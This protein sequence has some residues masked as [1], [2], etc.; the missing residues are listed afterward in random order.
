M[1]IAIERRD[2][3]VCEIIRR[4]LPD[5]GVAFLPAVPLRFGLEPQELRREF[6]AGRLRFD[7]S[8]SLAPDPRPGPREAV[9][10]YRRA[11]ARGGREPG[12][13]GL[14]ATA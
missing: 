7:L 2:C 12:A 14:D 13:A 11:Q 8:G 9:G 3:P 5:S 10:M 6:E 1:L 4:N